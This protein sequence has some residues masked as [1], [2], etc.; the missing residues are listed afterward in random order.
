MEQV[1]A[2]VGRWGFVSGLIEISDG[3]DVSSEGEA[4]LL[5]FL[6]LWIDRLAVVVVDPKQL[7]VSR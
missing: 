1:H 2:S 7:S 6:D 3:Y 4:L 5:V